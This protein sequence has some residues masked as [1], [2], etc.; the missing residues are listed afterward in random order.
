MLVIDPT[1][2]KTSNLQTRIHAVQTSSFLPAASMYRICGAYQ[3]GPVRMNTFFCMCSTAAKESDSDSLNFFKIE[4]DATYMCQPLSSGDSAATLR[5]L[6]PSRSDIFRLCGA[7][8]GCGKCQE[9]RASCIQEP[10]TGW[11]RLRTPRGGQRAILRIRD[12]GRISTSPSH[13]PSS[14]R[15]LR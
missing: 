9:G 6:Q 14:L 11:E 5:L 2:M 3:K 8:N 4:G 1:M 15:C 10:I 12:Q 13:P 7:L